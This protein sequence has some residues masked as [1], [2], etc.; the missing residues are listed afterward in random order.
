MLAFF[1]HFSIMAKI[2]E[3]S[4]YDIATETRLLDELEKTPAVLKSMGGRVEGV[5]SSW[6]QRERVN[7]DYPDVSVLGEAVQNG[8]VRYVS[9][10][11][12]EPQ[13]VAPEVQ[14]ALLL[15]ALMPISRRP[16]SLYNLTLL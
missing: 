4:Q 16:F 3:G 8:F 10:K 12:D 5:L 11:L 9:K 7:L 14:S 13:S 2:P 1:A 6:H 15:S